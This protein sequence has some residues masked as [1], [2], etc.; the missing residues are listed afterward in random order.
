MAATRR[1]PPNDSMRDDSEIERIPCL[2]DE[3]TETEALGNDDPA[4]RFLPSSR[5]P[6]PN[7][8]RTASAG[9]LPVSEQ[10]GDLLSEDL[11]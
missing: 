11:N 7:G 3:A 6:N 2:P 4:A 5:R 1:V 9:S 10:R 8:V